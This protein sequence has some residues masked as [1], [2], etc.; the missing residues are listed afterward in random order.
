[1][2]CSAMDSSL[3][4]LLL[5]QCLRL[6]QPQLQQQDR[7]IQLLLVLFAAAQHAHGNLPD[8]DNIILQEE[9]AGF[10]DAAAVLAR[11]RAMAAQQL[12]VEPAVRAFV[13]K[14]VADIA[15]VTTGVLWTLPMLLSSLQQQQAAACP[16]APEALLSSLH[17]AAGGG[18]TGSHIRCRR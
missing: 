14:A 11:A 5:A 12:A 16:P 6:T 18:T 7:R 9:V 10:K 1:M 17:V 13:R 4:A 2:Q 3:I 8:C 15:T